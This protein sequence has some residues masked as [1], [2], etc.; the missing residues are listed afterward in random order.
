MLEPGAAVEKNKAMKSLEGIKVLYVPMTI[1]TRAKGGGG[2]HH[3]L[4]TVDF[5]EKQVKMNESN[6]RNHE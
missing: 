1:G 6:K 3:M 2:S 4:C 5:T